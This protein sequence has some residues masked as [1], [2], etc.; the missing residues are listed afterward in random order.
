MVQDRLV[1]LDFGSQYTHL[2][3]VAYDSLGIATEIIPADARFADHAER[4]GPS[5]KG[6]VLSG[7]ASSV[8]LK[9]I[10]FDRH[11]IG[12]GRPVL[13]LC[14]G[15]QL[16]ASLFGGDVGRE[17]S[18]FGD[19]RVSIIQ[20]GV[21]FTGIS[22][23]H[24][25]TWMSHNDSVLSLPASFVVTARSASGA[26]AAM[27][28][29][30]RRLYGLQF[31]PE[32]SHTQSGITMLSNFALRI[33][34]ARAAQKWTPEAFVEEK[35]EEIRATVG[36]RRVI[37]G[38]SGGVDS[39]VMTRLIRES[40]PREQLVAIYVD[41]GLMPIQTE[42]EVQRFCSEN[43]IRLQV[44]READRFFNDLRGVT[45]SF[46]KCKVIG[47]AFIEAFEVVARQH[48]AEVFAQGTIWSDVVESGVTKF[49][50]QIKPHHNVGGLPERLGFELLEPMRYLFKDQVRKVGTLFRLPDAVVHKKVFPGPGFAIRVQGEVTRE[51]V[52][53]VRE[54]TEIVED[55]IN[56]SPVS[57]D[58]WMAFSILVDVPSLGVKGDRHVKNEQ[59][60]VIR[61][62]ESSNSMTANF[63]QSV[64]PYL[65][66]ISKRITDRM[67][68][69]RV[70]YDITDKPPATIEWQ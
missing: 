12:T 68:I 47:R 2:I 3:K 49:S 6:I 26:V 25:T 48:E 50:S 66:E 5:L 17:Q 41:S 70:V 38:L 9:D 61:A 14:Y 54:S 31:H 24:L 43:D 4:L 51:R 20:R 67:D 19:T 45:E 52:A 35:K 63:S 55:V 13:G 36:K 46:D 29:S 30:G 60:I 18:E 44:I 59:A 53:L 64:F 39:Y 56:R 57:R 1:V 69:G 33:C 42:F 27:E 22:A 40:L 16:L 62:V 32:V 10:D 11:W 58:V 28:D 21:L 15:H 8:Q 65:A 23:E 7:G 34:D 37:V